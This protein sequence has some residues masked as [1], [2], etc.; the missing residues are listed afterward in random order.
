MVE[1]PDDIEAALTAAGRTYWPTLDAADP[2]LGDQLANESL[3]GAEVLAGLPD[4]QQTVARGVPLFGPPVSR[5][6]SSVTANLRLAL[7]TASR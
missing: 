5:H 3:T 6:A 4:G 2:A 7:R 1:V